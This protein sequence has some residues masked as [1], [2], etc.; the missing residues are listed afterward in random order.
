MDDFLRQV[1]T[2]LAVTPTHWQALTDLVDPV[3]LTRAPRPGEWSALDCLRHLV[4]TERHVFPVRVNAILAGETFAAFDPDA[5]GAMEDALPPP[6]LAEEL[7]RLRAASIVDLTTL[8]DAD[9]P[10][11]GIHPELGQVTLEQLLNEWVAHDLMHT[12][13]A[14]RALMQPF[15]LATGP[16]RHYFK[17]HDVGA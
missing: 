13:Q 1:R 7:I 15:I 4:M 11:T 14:Q 9:L 2:I 16:W 12:V 3:L 6:V 10:R 17:D 5:S 8:Q